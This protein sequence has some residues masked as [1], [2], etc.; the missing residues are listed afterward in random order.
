LEPD[1]LARAQ[2]FPDKYYLHGTKAE[3]VRQIGNAVCPPV[4]K[5]LCETVAA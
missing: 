2:G 3:Q 1:E 5:A 4:A